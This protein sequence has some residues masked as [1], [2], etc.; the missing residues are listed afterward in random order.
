MNK[1]ITENTAENSAADTISEY[2]IGHTIYKVKTV[3]NPDFH[4]SLSDILQRLVIEECNKLI[5]ETGQK[6]EKQAV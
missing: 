1:N 6:S 5:S 4:E 3:F 2:K